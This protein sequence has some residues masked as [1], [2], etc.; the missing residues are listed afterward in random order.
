MVASAS[1]VGALIQ[2]ATSSDVA[3]QQTSNS[4]YWNSLSSTQKF[5]GVLQR[6]VSRATNGNVLI[7]KNVFS[8]PVKPTFQ[9]GNIFNKW[10]GIGIAALI[11]KHIPRLP[12]RG[13]VGKFAIPL[14]AG[15][16]IGGLLDDP[17]GQAVARSPSPALRSGAMT[18]S[19][20]AH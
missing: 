18:T 17:S 13:K 6:F 15:G 9:L 8:D 2:Q 20:N 1:G 7:F 10:T 4:G 11:Y 5:E 12:Q 3:Y 14:I 16:I 19:V